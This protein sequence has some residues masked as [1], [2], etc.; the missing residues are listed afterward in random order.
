VGS[1][2]STLLILSNTGGNELYVKA[3]SAPDWLD[4]GSVRMLIAASR[5]TENGMIKA[6]LIGAASER[7]MRRWEQIQAA[8]IQQTQ[9][10]RT[11][12]TTSRGGSRTTATSGLKPLTG[13]I[14]DTAKRLSPGVLA[15]VPEY[16]DFIMNRNKRLS[17]ADATAIAETILA[18]SA[19]YGVDA[20]LIMALVMV[21]SGFDPYG[22]SHVGAQGL[23]QL[24]PSTA[25]G[26]GVSNAYNT[27]ENLF[28]TVKLIRKHIDKYTKK[29]GDP[30]QGLV[31]ALA[32]YNAGSGN[33]SKHG[34]VPP[35][36]ETQNHIRK[37]MAAYKQFT[38]GD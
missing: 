18:Y 27:E 33:V 8:K 2:G 3:Q 1:G 29:T 22:R 15:V 34:G 11:T 28:G 17:A 19:H 12:P 5:P 30:Y 35:F 20:R 31:L 6:D 4:G 13:A 37:V 26:L 16:R 7:E 25:K 36:K 32:A 10:R 9:K 14:G 23:G 38:S 24:M 21:E